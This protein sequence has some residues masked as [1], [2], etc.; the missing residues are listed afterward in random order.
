MSDDIRTSKPSP[1]AGQ[2]DDEK[3]QTDE[4]KIQE[5]IDQQRANIGALPNNTSNDVLNRAPHQKKLGQLE[6]Q[7]QNLVEK[8]RLARELSKFEEMHGA[9]YSE[10]CLI[11]LDNIHVRHPR[12]C[13][14]YSFAVVV[15]FAKAARGIPRNQRSGSTNVHCVGNL[16]MK[17]R[18][19]NPPRN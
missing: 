17:H 13:I 11:C 12:N 16:F 6:F 3:K 9:I 1:K 7:Y 8:K 2:E 15:S 4:E 14:N 5:M 18:W 19:Q 10:P